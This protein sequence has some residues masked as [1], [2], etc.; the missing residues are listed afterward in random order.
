MGAAIA[1]LCI[2]VTVQICK[3]VLKVTNTPVADTPA[4]DEPAPAAGGS[5]EVYVVITALDYKQTSNPLTCSIDG[6]NMEK[7]IRNCGIPQ[8]NIT[9]MY[10]EQCTKENVSDVVRQMAS[11]CGAGDYFIFYYSGHGTNMED[12]SGDEEDGQDEA[13]CFVTPDGQVSY[14]SCMVDDDFSDL[15]TGSFDE[16]VKIIILTDCCHSGT[17]ADF[18]TGDWENRQAI[19][20]TGCLDGQTSGD[21][22][23]G[24]IFTH[25][26][27]LALGE[28]KDEDEADYSVAKVYNRTL[29][30]DDEVFHSKQDICLQCAPGYRPN[31]MAWPLVPEGDWQPPLGHR[32]GDGS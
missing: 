12:Q 30:K 16:E 2:F 19:S 15:I 18:E 1:P 24:G 17:I 14:D 9:A 22:G 5:G 6:R 32:S 28:L 23:K 29:K 20:I 25:S 26:M 4:Y 31:Q 21:I 3:Q 27:L 11:R 10:D 7:L 13:F 8:E